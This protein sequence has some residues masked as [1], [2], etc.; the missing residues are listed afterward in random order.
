M[1]DNVPLSS[2]ESQLL[3]LLQE[4]ASLSVADL[5]DATNSSAA[6]I[7]RRIRS[8]EERGIIG[9]PVR[10]VDPAKVGRGMD[11]YC[12]VRMKSQDARARAAFQQ[13]VDSEPAIVE[14]YSITGD[15]DYMLHMVV[16][17]I[18]DFEDVLMRR[19]LDLD[20]VAS[21]STL[22]A[23]RRIKHTSKVPV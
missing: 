16:R 9:P 2:L 21:T 15:W 11:V 17:D 13:A 18:A 4:D 5:A 1:N 20:C 19:L 23:L 14:V 12:Q 3:S 10:L 7:W 8:L 6:T 22:F